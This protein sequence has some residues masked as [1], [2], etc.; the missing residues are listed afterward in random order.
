MEPMTESADIQLEAEPIPETVPVESTSHAP[1]PPSIPVDTPALPGDTPP[2]AEASPPAVEEVVEKV[3]VEVLAAKKRSLQ[4]V[5]EESK[6][7]G[8]RM[9]GLLQSTLAQAQKQSGAR[10]GASKKRQ[11]IEERLAAKLSAERAEMEEKRRRDREGKD[12]RLAVTRKEEEIANFESIVR[13]IS[14]V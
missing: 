7:R 5:A 3:D 11:E 10:A 4:I 6:K 13:V 8:K 1:S 2:R 14:L 12:L 9:F